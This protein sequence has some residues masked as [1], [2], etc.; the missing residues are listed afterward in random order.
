MVVVG[1]SETGHT[2]YLNDLLR[3]SLHVPLNSAMSHGKEISLLLRVWRSELDLSYRN[4]LVTRLLYN[5]IRVL[6]RPL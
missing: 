1:V 6:S 3:F 5:L 2:N 4:E